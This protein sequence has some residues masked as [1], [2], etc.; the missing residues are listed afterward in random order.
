MDWSWLVP[1]DWGAI[2]MPQAPLLEVVLRGSIVYLVLFVGLRVVLKREAA[3][4]GISDLLVVVLL[5]DA[6]QNGMAE[7]ATSIPDALLLGFTIIGWSWFL[8]WLAWR[9]RPLRAAIRPRPIP[10]IRDGKTIAKTCR[11]EMLTDDEIL[12]ELRQQGIERIADVKVAYMEGNG[13]I[14]A[15]PKDDTRKKAETKTVRS[16]DRL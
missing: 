10:L 16:G 4:L 9:W 11:R 13:V 1:T 14:T 15:I 3:G 7:G 8:S 6:V 5:A 2:F 12:A